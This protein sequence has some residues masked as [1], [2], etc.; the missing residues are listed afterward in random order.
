MTLTVDQMEAYAPLASRL[1]L[2][3]YYQGHDQQASGSGQR[4]HYFGVMKSDGSA[5]GGAHQ[6]GDRPGR[7]APR[8]LSGSP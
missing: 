4:E 5:K 1:R 6:R 7:R 3:T 8:S 2:F